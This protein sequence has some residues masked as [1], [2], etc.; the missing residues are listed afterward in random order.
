M[1]VLCDQPSIFTL[2]NSTIKAKS[3][4]KIFYHVVNKKKKLKNLV[5]ANQTVF[6][7]TQS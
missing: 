3:K 5:A 2:W 1:Y 4:V 7:D 6:R